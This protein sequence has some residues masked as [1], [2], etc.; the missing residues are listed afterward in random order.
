MAFVCMFFLHASVVSAVELKNG[1]EISS[2][3]SQSGEKDSY[4]FT[5]NSGEN[6]Q[7]RVT[8]VDGTNFAPRIDVFGPSGALKQSDAGAVVAAI[9]FHTDESGDHIAIVSDGTQVQRE[10]G[11]YK[12]YYT[13]SPGANE[14]GILTSGD[15]KSDEIDLGDL[16]SY[17]FK[18]N[19][20]EKVKIKVTDTDGSSL[21]PRIDV[22]GPRGDLKQSDADSTTA[23][24]DFQ[25]DESGTYT[26]IVSDG[27]QRPRGTGP[28]Q[29]EFALTPFVRITQ[30]VF[31]DES[32]IKLVHERTTA[33]IVDR[34]S[35]GTGAVTLSI[36]DKSDG[37]EKFSTSDFKPGSKAGEV[38]FYCDENLAESYC[39]LEKDKRYTFNVA[40]SSGIAIGKEVDVEVVDTQMLGL[41]FLFLTVAGCEIIP[42]GFCGVSESSISK[43]IENSGKFVQS[44]FPLQNEGLDVLGGSLDQI[45]KIVGTQPDD[46][47]DNYFNE[48]I[49]IGLKNKQLKQD[50]TL[51]RK[52]SKG[53][54]KYPIVFVP[55]FY[56]ADLGFSVSECGLEL[57]GVSFINVND[58]SINSA[59]V[60]AHELG[61][62]LGLYPTL[63]LGDIK[64]PFTDLIIRPSEAYDQNPPYGFPASGF[65]VYAE[66]TN[67]NIGN[68]IGFMGKCSANK[69]REN[70]RYWVYNDDWFELMDILSENPDDPEILLIAGNIGTFGSVE[71][72][73][74]GTGT[75]FP[76]KQQKG[77]F[78]LILKQ[79]NGEIISI[80][81]VAPEF[82]IEIEAFG[83][84]ITDTGF[85][86][87]EVAYPKN[88][89]S[90]SLE[91]PSGAELIR[92]DPV[93]KAITDIFS[94]LSPQ[95]LRSDSAVDKPAIMTLANEVVRLTEDGRS[96][97]AAPTITSLEKIV[98]NDL[99]DQCSLPGTEFQNIGQFQSTAI[100]RLSRY[101][102]RENLPKIELLIGDLD[103]D[104][105]VDRDDLNILMAHRN[106]P[107]SGEDDPMDLDGDG[108]ITGL[109]ARILTQLCTRP[110]CATE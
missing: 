63:F 21:A 55:S 76:S 53:N 80:H 38:I 44:T 83:R 66:T 75:G 65:D 1:G 15:V 43:T 37:I 82:S 14:G 6:I 2:S 12:V 89:A 72:F 73:T 13:R 45:K 20:G 109:D 106:Q 25:T 74:L 42:G 107:A 69:E 9:N 77:N 99:E 108:Q 40:D 48:S 50:V 71:L 8:D 31:S 16:D 95:C 17:T 93:T 32:P 29:I 97:E 101:R 91:S 56:F 22:Y 49:V 87:I 90:V 62:A 28:Y 81:P 61:H 64:I 104:G 85:F 11:S 35:S 47:V 103:H 68:A 26:V 88:T 94:E 39:N 79:K 98:I 92:F 78:S 4:T 59:Q 33:I 96:L 51:I 10:T 34:G 58:P 102:V 105:D 3:I 7:I 36:I 100:E 54:K 60:V 57:G 19:G 84:L 67:A 24:I 52:V 5:A 70:N 30:A 41:E 23:V 46:R 110:R 86:I 18:A 27:S